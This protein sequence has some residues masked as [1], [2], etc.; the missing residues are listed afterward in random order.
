MRYVGAGGL[1]RHFQS[2]KKRRLRDRALRCSSWLLITALAA[3]LLAAII[4]PSQTGRATHFDLFAICA[5]SSL[6]QPVDSTGTPDGEAKI[7]GGGLCVFCL[8]LM[9]ETLAVPFQA[10]FVVLLL[11]FIVQ[12]P[13]R[14]DRA[15]R[16]ISVRAASARA[17]PR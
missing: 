13:I 6:F 12:F 2:G 5:G 14:E 3:N 16:K 17:P 4:L 7:E 11:A 1:F 8:P 10:T 9:K 15:L